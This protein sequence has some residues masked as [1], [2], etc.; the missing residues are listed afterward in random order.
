MAM[1]QRHGARLWGPFGFYD[2]FNF[3]RDWV[4]KTY[5]CIDVGPI[6]PMIENYRTG[7]C[8]STFMRAPEI[9]SVVK[10]LNEGEVLRYQKIQS[11]VGFNRANFYD[12]NSDLPV[13]G[14]NPVGF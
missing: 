14:G 11:T 10:M 1:Y 12:A 6:A 5:L 8:W 2:S 3:T 7:M 9:Q 13:A 4:S